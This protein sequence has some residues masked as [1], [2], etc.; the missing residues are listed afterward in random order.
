M[1]GRTPLGGR[2]PVRTLALRDDAPGPAAGWPWDLPVLARLRAAPLDL[3]PL[4]VLVGA[5]GSGKSTLLEGL[6]LA[7]GL[8]SEGGSVHARHTT[9]PTE[10][11]L[12]GALQVTRGAGASR[13]GFFLRAETMHGFFTYLEEHAGG[14]DPVFHEMSHGE[15]F[16]ALV[17]RRFDGAGLYLLDEPESALSFENCLGLA[18]VLHGLAGR[19]DAQV[20]LATHSPV[21]AAIPG[22]R[23]LELGP[24]GW[25]ESTWE[26]L[27][28]VG[29]WRTFLADPQRYWRHVL[30]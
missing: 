3:G 30:E 23:V 28:L 1:A 15:S 18:G 17:G 21:L 29:H 13:W 26:D 6:A 7:V 12:S 2:L 14:D 25:A 10:S 24:D 11:D 22:A 27:Q 8:S 9:R 4:T 16:V 5:N 19:G 20:V